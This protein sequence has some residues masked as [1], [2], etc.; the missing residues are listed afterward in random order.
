MTKRKK[1]TFVSFLPPFLEREKR[2]EL[3]T[4]TLARWHSTAEL[5]PRKGAAFT[6]RG[7]VCQAWDL[8]SENFGRPVGPSGRPGPPEGCLALAF[9]RG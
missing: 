3:S 4:S 2:F 7:G 6:I 8:F 1:P 5:L 9:P